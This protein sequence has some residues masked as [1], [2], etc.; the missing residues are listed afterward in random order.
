M[1]EKEREKID[2]KLAVPNGTCTDLRLNVWQKF[3]GAGT[4][5]RQVPKARV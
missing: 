3:S 5:F 1:E 2:L 4:P